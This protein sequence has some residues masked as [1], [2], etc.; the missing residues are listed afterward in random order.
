[1]CSAV[2]MMLQE[3]CSSMFAAICNI[4]EKNLSQPH[5]NQLKTLWLTGEGAPGPWEEDKSCLGSCLHGIPYTHTLHLLWIGLVN[6]STAIS[7]CLS[8]APWVCGF[9]VA[10]L[11]GSMGLPSSSSSIALSGFVLS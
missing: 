2:C 7:I 11:A 10:S 4:Q 9:E 8:L 1:M 6:I 5:L 3:V